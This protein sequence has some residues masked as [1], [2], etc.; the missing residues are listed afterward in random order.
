[1][2]YSF[3]HI[4]NLLLEV[5]LIKKKMIITSLFFKRKQIIL[6]AWTIEEGVM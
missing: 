5:E 4:I 6:G 3:K 1:M 2:Q